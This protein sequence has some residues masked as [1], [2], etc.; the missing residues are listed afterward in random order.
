MRY[1]YAAL[2]IL[3]TAA[4]LVCMGQNIGSVTVS[5]VTMRFTLLLS[6]LVVL[7]YVL[8]MFTDGS[9]PPPPAARRAW[10][11]PSCASSRKR[12]LSPMNGSTMRFSW[13]V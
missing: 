10:S 3:L 7:A 8:G 6:V 13:P 5:Y 2:A 4:V 12:L 11:P 1:P 9:S